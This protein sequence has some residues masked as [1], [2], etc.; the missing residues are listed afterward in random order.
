MTTE[1]VVECGDGEWISCVVSEPRRPAGVALLCH[2]L[3]GDSFGPAGL[4]RRMAEALVASGVAVIRFDAR[5]CAD[6]SAGPDTPTVSTMAQ[7][8]VTV[9]ADPRLRHLG[10]LPLVLCGVSLG[11][12]AVARAAHR[13]PHLRGVVALSSDLAD[14]EDR[15]WPSQ[16]SRAAEHRL[17]DGFAADLLGLRPRQD[18]RQLGVP[19]AVIVGERDRG[20][21]AA[22]ELRAL[23]FSVDVV[24]DG[25]HLYQSASSAAEMLATLGWRVAEMV[26]PPGDDV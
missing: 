2:G 11:A 17:P 16:W 4:L 20:A 5:G 6:S 3:T 25:D 10:S 9:L 12:M 18:L 24:A 14:G 15:P 21:A 26:S 1:F 23:G 22:P 7:D 8:V 13:V 19:V